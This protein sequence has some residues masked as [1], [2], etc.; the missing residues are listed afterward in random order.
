MKQAVRGKIWGSTC[1]L[2]DQSDVEIDRISVKANGYCSEHKHDHKWNAFFVERGCL[3]I[4]IYREDA[5]QIIEDVT[6]LQA[7]EMTYVEP[8]LYHK[9]IATEDTVAFEIYWVELSPIDISRR[10]VGGIS[11]DKT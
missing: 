1:I 7:G 9:F 4:I 6:V 3:K 8:G 5:K 10:N 2:F 11:E